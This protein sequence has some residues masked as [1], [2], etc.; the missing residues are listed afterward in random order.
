[1]QARTKKIRCASPTIRN[2]D[3]ARQSTP[4]IARK[5]SS[6]RIAS[7]AVLLRSTPMALPSRSPMVAARHPVGGG[8]VARREYRN[9]PSSSRSCSGRG[10]PERQEVPSRPQHAAGGY[11]AEHHPDEDLRLLDRWA[12]S[13]ALCG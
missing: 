3:S 4:L 11:Q 8:K 12:S 5:R 10:Y 1:W 6:S 9:S 2:S 7:R 13:T